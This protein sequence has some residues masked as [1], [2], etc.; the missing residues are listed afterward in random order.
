MFIT[1]VLKMTYSDQESKGFLTIYQVGD[2]PELY[3]T[4]APTLNTTKCANNYYMEPPPE[5]DM[6]EPCQ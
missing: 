2:H 3:E 4:L 5:T 6:S 1:E